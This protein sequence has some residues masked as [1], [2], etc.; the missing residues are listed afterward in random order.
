M[1]QLESD[2][3]KNHLALGIAYR[4][5]GEL[6]ESRSELA[7]ALKSNPGW[8]AAQF[9]MGETL[10]QMKRI[11]DAMAYYEQAAAGGTNKT[12]IQNRMAEVYS[13]SHQPARAIALY[14]SL[15]AAG[16]ANLRTYECYASILQL[17][18]QFK[19]TEE[20]LKEACQRFP[21]NSMG[22][23]RLGLHYA[24]LRE[25]DSSLVPLQKARRLA[26]ADRRIL[27]AISLAEL[28][29]GKLPQATASARRLLEVA[30]SSLEDQVYLAS[31]L[32]LNKEDQEAARIY[33]KVLQTS[34]ANVVALN[35]LALIHLRQNQ[36]DQAVALAAKAASQQPNDSAVQ[37]TYGWALYRKGDLANARQFLENAANNSENPTYNYHLA[38]IYHA[39][40][41]KAEAAKQAELATS[42]SKSF[43]EREQA[44]RLLSELRGRP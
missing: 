23:Y 10:V 44:L 9:Q 42:Q 11:P 18:D 29:L 15:R 14:Q 2:A 3:A 27:K 35:N 1:C 7:H 36:I 31:L 21:E 32:E 25:Y 5:A 19:E 37:D 26:P 17:T 16:Q 6:E 12:A 40:G 39:L 30:P 4:E 22:Y 13:R 41:L 28:R 43:P 8:T 24:L 20:V 33:E 38:A 34:P